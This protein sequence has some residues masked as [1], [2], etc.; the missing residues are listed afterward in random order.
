MK[1]SVAMAT[2]NGAEYIIEQLDSILNQTIKVDEVIICDDCSKDDTAVVV[3]KYIADHE[4]DESWDFR[5]NEHNLGYA[6]NFVK[7]LRKTTGDMIFFCDQ[8]D[9]WVN[10][11]IEKMVSVMEKNPGIMLMGSEFEPFSSTADAPKPHGWELAT[12]RGDESL[13]H[14]KFEP[15]NIF[16]GCQGCTMGMRREFI[17]KIDRYWYPG[18]AHDEYVWK[19]ALCMDGLYFYH[20][21]TLKRRLHSNN[22][23]LHKEHKKSQRMKYLIDLLK[24]HEQTLK[25]ARDNELSEK[26]VRLLKK[27]IRA[28]KMR[29]DLIDKRKL[30]NVIPLSI[31][32]WNCYHKCRAIPV[33]IVMALKG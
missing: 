17:D 4:L 1:I 8:D 21:V 6:S 13:E 33:E 10:N 2:Y 31:K 28:T 11:R 14:L 18:W 30:L 15:K 7:A 27:N 24:S 22:V 12:F 32:Y 3:K 5:V 9:I 29:I 20:A 26:K 16:I 25:F 19:L 23:T